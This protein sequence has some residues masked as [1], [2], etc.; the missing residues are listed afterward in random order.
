MIPRA[1]NQVVLQKYMIY[2]FPRGPGIKIASVLPPVQKHRV[3][4]TQLVESKTV[5]NR[6]YPDTENPLQNP[7]W[8][9][10]PYIIIYFFFS[11][12]FLRASEIKNIPHVSS[13]IM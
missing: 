5:Y 2:Y 6:R 8:V 7:T 11:L 12:S 3:V 13:E 9:K 4:I 1:E 10:S